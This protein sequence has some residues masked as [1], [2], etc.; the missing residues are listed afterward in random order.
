MAS[1]LSPLRPLP[2]PQQAVVDPRSG[3]MTRD[4]YL[5]FTS[6]SEHIREIEKRLDATEGRLDAGGL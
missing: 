6:E 5:Y 3:L 2:S 1:K 4:W